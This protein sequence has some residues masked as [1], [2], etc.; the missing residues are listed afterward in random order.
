MAIY[1]NLNSDYVIKTPLD[2]GSNI[3]L[4]T[5]TVIIPGNLSVLGTTLSITTINTEIKDKII[6]LNVGES[7]AGVGGGTGTAGIEIDRGSLANVQLRWDE[8][9]AKWQLTSDGSVYANIITSTTGSTALTAV[10]EDTAPVLGG[11]LNVN[12]FTIGANTNVILSGNLQLNNTVVMPTAVNGAAVL[13]ASAPNSG[14]AGLYVVNQT[15]TNEE[16]ITRRRA[17][18]F[19]LLLG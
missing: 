6:A 18:G 15:S 4:S 11:N 17:F 5:D 10:V 3:T 1:K 7:G 2:T 13:Y 16:L 19:S 8:Q 9:V 12:G 14:A